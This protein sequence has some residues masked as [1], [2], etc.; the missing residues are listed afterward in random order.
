MEELE[1]IISDDDDDID[2]HFTAPEVFGTTIHKI[3]IAENEIVTS[4]D[5]T[6]NWEVTTA[7]I[8]K[9]ILGIDEIIKNKTDEEEQ[10]P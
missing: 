8:M 9:T 3:I 2:F 1:V 4:N 5:V 7:E 6:I 10:L